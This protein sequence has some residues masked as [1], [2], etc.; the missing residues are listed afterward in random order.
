[1][2]LSLKVTFILDL[3]LL[4]SNKIRVRFRVGEIEPEFAKCKYNWLSATLSKEDMK[5]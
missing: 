2:R 4:Q 5:I 1:M 3:L